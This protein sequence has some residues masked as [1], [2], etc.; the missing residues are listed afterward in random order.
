MYERNEILV[1]EVYEIFLQ[2]GHE[3]DT[4]AITISERRL[5]KPS[6]RHASGSSMATHTVSL[7]SRSAVKRCRNG[8][9]HAQQRGA[10]HLGVAR[11]GHVSKGHDRANRVISRVRETKERERA[12]LRLVEE[13][14]VTVAIFWGGLHGFPLSQ[15]VALCVISCVCSS[16]A[17]ARNWSAHKL[18]HSFVRNRLGNAN[19]EK[20]VFLYFNNKIKDEETAQFLLSLDEDFVHDAT[21]ERIIT[22]RAPLV[23]LDGIISF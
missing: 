4:V 18:M 10:V 19:L 2:L 6:S 9:G 23:M 3:Y 15:E 13:G 14:K 5:V 21:Q 12:A 7:P 16:T 8:R 17:A 20:V 11:A 22:I 1:S